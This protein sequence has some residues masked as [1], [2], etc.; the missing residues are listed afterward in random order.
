MRKT[1]QGI[2][3]EYIGRTRRVW[4]SNVWVGKKIRAENTWPTAVL[5]Y[6]LGTER[7]KGTGQIDKNATPTKKGLVQNAFEIAQKY[8]IE[9]LLRVDKEGDHAPDPRSAIREIRAKQ[10]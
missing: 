2:E 4:E 9:D 10:R 1:K 6:S 5:R 8:E 7:S 3:R